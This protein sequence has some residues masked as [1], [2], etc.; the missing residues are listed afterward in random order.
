MAHHITHE[1]LNSMLAD[2]LHSKHMISASF[3]SWQPLAQGLVL[4]ASASD[5][6]PVS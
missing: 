5:T 4:H 1:M 3:V 6:E 2:N